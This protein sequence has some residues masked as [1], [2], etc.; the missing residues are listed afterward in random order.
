MCSDMAVSK[1]SCPKKTILLR[2][3]ILLRQPYFTQTLFLVVYFPLYRLDLFKIDVRLQIFDHCGQNREFIVP[4]LL[5]E[6]NLLKLIQRKN[7]RSPYT[8]LLTAKMLRAKAYSIG[9]PGIRRSQ[10][11]TRVKS[12]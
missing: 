9:I 2:D 3:L 8:N 11:Y 5:E 10:I 6:L 1:I 4:I 12:L 7:T